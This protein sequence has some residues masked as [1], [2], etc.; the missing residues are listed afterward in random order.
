M[1]H[2][3]K[4]IFKLSHT[5]NSLQCSQI[6]MFINYIHYEF[7]HTLKIYLGLTL[8]TTIRECFNKFQAFYMLSVHL[9]LY[10]LLL[11][12]SFEDMWSCSELLWWMFKRNADWDHLTWQT[13]SRNCKNTGDLWD[14][15]SGSPKRSLKRCPNVIQSFM[16]KI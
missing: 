11:V 15:A 9:R 3:R 12:N 4:T 1:T 2:S 8:T 13:Q 16:I 10:L 14:G 6:S 5:F 7:F